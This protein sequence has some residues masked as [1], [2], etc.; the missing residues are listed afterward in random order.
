MSLLVDFD[1]DFSARNVLFMRAFYELSWMLL[2]TKPFFACDILLQVGGSPTY[3]DARFAYRDPPRVLMA[4]QQPY[5]TSSYYFNQSKFLII[6]RVHLKC[7]FSFLYQ[8]L[9]LVK[10]RPD[11]PADRLGSYLVTP[12]LHEHVN[13]HNAKRIRLLEAEQQAAKEG[14]PISKSSLAPATAA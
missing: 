4:R 5:S 8:L 6:S 2:V 14:K 1:G 11:N 3:S 7:V 12:N 9:F 13:Q 10:Q